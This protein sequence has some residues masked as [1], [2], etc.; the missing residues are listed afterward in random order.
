MAEALTVAGPDYVNGYQLTLHHI[1]LGEDER[2]SMIIHNRIYSP[3]RG[4]A[5]MNQR[6]N[7]RIIMISLIA[8]FLLAVLPGAANVSYAL[9]GCAAAGASGLT[10]KV[11]ATSGQVI[12]GTIDAT[13]CDV[14]V[15]VGPGVTGVTIKGATITGANDHGIFVQDT[16]GIVIKD[17]T[18]A[19]NGVAPHD[20]VTENKAIELVGTS[21]SVVKDNT[22]SH[23]AAD[24]GIGVADD[25]A[26]NPGAPNPGASLP[27]KGNLVTGNLIEYNLFGC[28]IVVASYNSAGVIGNLVKGNTVLGA[29]YSTVSTYGPAV[30]GIVVATDTPF[31][32]AVD[33]VVIGNFV[34]GALIPGIVVHSNAPGDVVK[35][36]V[37]MLNTLDYNGYE[38]P[39]PTEPVLPT[40][41]MVVAEAFPGETPEPIITNTFIVG[42]TVINNYYGVFINA[43]TNTFIFAL[44][45][46]ATVPVFYN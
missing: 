12:T 4:K 21:F 18:V 14:G 3:A 29:T 46:N 37:I 39:A 2:P 13:T 28:G 17:N 11:V 6:S 45:G 30:G 33:N 19:G 34:Q 44:K 7:R 43:A 32:K 22:V 36:T 5:A 38:G 1:A 27:G 23:N 25:G 16:T 40:G 8:A 42:N 20:T 10:A 15:Y 35:G 24:G 31:S 26:F 41:I 9:P